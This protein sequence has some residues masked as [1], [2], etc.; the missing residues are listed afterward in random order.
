MYTYTYTHAR[1]GPE[2]P[3]RAHLLGRL[4]LRAEAAPFRNKTSR[5]YYPYAQSTY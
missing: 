2:P 1:R 4:G 3:R 5:G